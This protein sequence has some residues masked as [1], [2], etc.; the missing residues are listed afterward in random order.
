M[1]MRTFGPKRANH[2]SIGRPCCVCGIPFKEG[3]YTV[4]I[5]TV[6]ASEE[7]RTKAEAGRPYVAEAQEAH[8]RCNLHGDDSPNEAI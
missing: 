2:P 1:T 8:S 5:P 7:E 6:P 3:D 4:L